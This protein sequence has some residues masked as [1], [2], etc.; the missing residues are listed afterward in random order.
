MAL[1]GGGP[2]GPYPFRHDAE[3]G[4][5]DAVVER[6]QSRTGTGNP[7]E[8]IA[9]VVD[10]DTATSKPRMNALWVIGMESAQEDTTL[11]AEQDY[12]DVHFQS[13]VAAKPGEGQREARRLSSI[14]GIEVLKGDNERPDPKLG[15][16][17]VTTAHFMRARKVPPPER[18]VFAHITIVRFYFYASPF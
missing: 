4:I 8:N 2:R 10:G 12:L 15:L 5:I 13:W 6:L 3:E 9:S 7:L 17:Y 18:G 14:A 11:A 1:G 16:P